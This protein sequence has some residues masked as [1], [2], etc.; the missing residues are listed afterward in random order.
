MAMTLDELLAATAAPPPVSGTQWAVWISLFV[1]Q[2]DGRTG[3]A[4]GNAARGA[5]TGGSD[6]E[7]WEM[8]LHFSD[9][10]RFQ[11]NPDR[12]SLTLTRIDATNIRINMR[13]ITW[14]SGYACDL[15]LPGDP[16][17]EGKLYAGRGTTI[18]NGAG[19]AVH[20]LTIIN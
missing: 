4:A 2:E 18:G 11:G 17:G 16:T 14:S 7:T 1:T 9:R 5:L 10:S 8:P 6:W 19:T 13:L 20:V 12:I 15:G 3:Y